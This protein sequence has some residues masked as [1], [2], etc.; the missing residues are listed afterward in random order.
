MGFDELNIKQAK[1][2][3]AYSTTSPDSINNG[4]SNP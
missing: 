4:Y 1:S 2:V 3:A